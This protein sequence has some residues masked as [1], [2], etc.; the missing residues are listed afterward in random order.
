MA[1]S[2]SSSAATVL[3]W[4][5]GDAGQLG[6]G[7]TKDRYVPGAVKELASGDVVKVASGGVGSSSTFAL[8]LG[9]DGTV[10]SWGDNA[11]GQLGN[12]NTTQQS[13]PSAV[14]TLAEIKDIAAGGMH[15]LALDADGQV[16]AWGDNAYGQLG[17]D[18]TGDDR[19][20][21]V[22]VGGLGKVKAIAAGADFSLA[23]METGKVYA[24]GRGIHGQ[25]GNGSRA[26]TSAPS[27]V[28]G[29]ENIVMIA[30]GAQHA[31]ALPADDT[32]KSWGYNLYG[33]LGTSSTKSSTLPVDVDWLEGV[34]EITAGAHHNY[35]KTSDSTVWGW[36]SNQYGQLPTDEENSGD[37]ASRANRTA[38]VELTLLKDAQA[39][40]AGARHG[41]AVIAGDVYA[42]GDNSEGQLGNGTTTPGY[43][44]V[45]LPGTGYTRV[46]ASL[47]GNTTYVY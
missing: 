44:K 29:L 36:G 25:L 15:A 30:A 22:R 2:P 32:I 5:A 20:T 35:A 18:S 19:S 37:N 4:G 23:L 9:S 46:A 42:F 38:P 47:A 13:V 16:Y 41:L 34:S 17:T 39:L 14:L 6:D 8:L 11:E 1:G 27:Q 21:P 33:Q 40:A 31:L 12:G 28:V 10:R 45:D 7:T 26:T 3:A 24:W 43:H